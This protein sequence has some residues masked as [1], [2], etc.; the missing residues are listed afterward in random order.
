MAVSSADGIAR[1]AATQQR[2]LPWYMPT[3]LV[4][5]STVGTCV[6]GA[7]AQSPTEALQHVG[8]NATADSHARDRP[9]HSPCAHKGPA[10]LY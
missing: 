1:A 2:H 5:Y 9:C 10:G 8:R 7:S 6:D 4:Q 3:Y